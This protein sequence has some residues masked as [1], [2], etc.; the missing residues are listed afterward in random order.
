[1]PAF[2]FSR[3]FCIS[4]NEEKNLLGG[5]T[6]D[7]MKFEMLIDWVNYIDNYEHTEP[8][9]FDRLMNWLSDKFAKIFPQTA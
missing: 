3:I 2:S 5:C 9:W 7:Q 1:M 4:L 8:D 6:M